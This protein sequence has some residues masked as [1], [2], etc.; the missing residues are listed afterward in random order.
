MQCQRLKATLT[1]GSNEGKR[2]EAHLEVAALSALYEAHH[3]EAAAAARLAQSPPNAP[4]A[5]T[6]VILWRHVRR[7]KLPLLHLYLILPGG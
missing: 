7:F 6:E 2:D 1:E 4:E 5:W 3:N